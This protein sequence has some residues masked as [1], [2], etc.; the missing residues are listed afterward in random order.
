MAP[1]PAS[2]VPAPP[3]PQLEP[4]EVLNR[5]YVLLRPLPAPGGAQARVWQATDEVLARPVAVKVLAARESPAAAFLEAAARAGAVE[6]RPLARIYDAAV[7]P[8]L[9]RPSLA[10]VISEWI[11]GEPLAEVLARGPLPAA[12]A[13]DLTLQAVGALVDAHAAGVVHGRLHP[14]NVH[15]TPAGRLRLTDAEVASALATPTERPSAADDVRDVAALLYAMLTARWPDDATG[16][17]ARGVPLAPH[18]GH[19]GYRPR[20]LRAGVPRA[21]DAVVVRALH[22]DRVDGRPPVDTAVALRTALE[23][24]ADEVL[25]EGEAAP[26]RAPG[27][28]RRLGPS[29]LVSVLLVVLAVVCYSLGL[30]V[31]ALPPQDD[32]R[33]TARTASAPAVAV[34]LGAAQLRDYDPFGSPPQ[35][36]P[37][38]VVNAFDGAASTAWSTEL[39]RTELFGNLKPG[40][41][42]LVDLGAPTALSEVDVDLA[43]AGATLELRAGDTLGPDQTLLPV[44]SSDGGHQVAVRLA[45]PPGTT[46]R[47]WL[48]W[49]TKLPRDGDQYRAAIEELR[50]LR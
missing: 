28:L 25:P 21:L 23:A 49:I 31:G 40:V 12:Q 16:Q 9:V 32:G 30:S 37:D 48:V 6:A 22:P 19:G 15:V 13:L 34:D 43:R 33:R 8:L 14:G 7:E 24:A 27:R 5:R 47:Y 20:Q 26:R 46:A 39:Y 2:A 3:R 1:G 18:G 4:G 29:L 38:S 45:V 41:G 35:E 50:L 11:E 44:V 10:Y 42:L 17:P 36:N